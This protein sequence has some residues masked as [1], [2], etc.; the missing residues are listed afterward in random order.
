M[1]VKKILIFL[2]GLGWLFMACSSTSK[3]PQEAW[4]F[5]QELLLLHGVSGYEGEVADYIQAK[6]PA[7][8][9]LQIDEMDNLWFTVG[10]GKPHLLFVAHTDELGLVVTQITEK[11]RLK[12]QGRGGFFSFMYEGY[13]VVIKTEKG[14]LEG[15]VEPRPDYRRFPPEEK[16]F[17][18]SDF[19]I[20]L[21][22]ETRQE[23]EALGV[24]IGDSITIHKE[25]VKIGDELIYARAVDDRAGCAAL[26][27]AAWQ[28][29]WPLIEGKTITFAWDVQEEIGLRG[30]TRLAEKIR[31]DYVFP[32]DTFV[33]SAGPLD[34]HRFGCLPLG[35][36]AVIR[37]IDSSTISPH[38][39]WP[40]VV[41][42]AAKKGLPLQWGNTR[43][44]N[45]GSAFM[46]Q[47]AVNIPLSWPGLYSHS[48]IEKIHR[49]DLETLTN[50]IIAIVEEF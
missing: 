41:Q 37:A 30:A 31:P 36:G 38:Q 1:T 20:Y 46:L 5:L 13:P 15:V 3:R 14:L 43:G 26:L 40:K 29:E 10:Q 11:G 50:L 2:V 47:G 25:V 24:K 45:D 33:S 22:V 23:A 27:A 42:I 32:V 6:L 39:A 7:G 16:K 17:G 44:G 8:L 49:F 9:P 4:N 35:Q 48:F 21:G 12:V 28:I 34:N 18:L 19:E